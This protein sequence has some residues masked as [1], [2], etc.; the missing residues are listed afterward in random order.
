MP[1][2]VVVHYRDPDGPTETLAAAYRRA[3][4]DLAG[5]PGLLGHE[6]LG[7]ID[8]DG[9]FA[10][11]MAWRDLASYRAWERR[12]RAAGHPSP[13]RKFQDRTRPGGHYEVYVVHDADYPAA[14]AAGAADPLSQ[15]SG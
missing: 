9:R 13:L 4:R 14:D 7:A 12:L 3:A 1:V 8:G 2:R 5:T 10:L 6:L 15:P 11:L